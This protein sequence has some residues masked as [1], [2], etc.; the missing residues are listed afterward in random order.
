MSSIKISELPAASTATGAER[1]PVVQAGQTVS[2]TTA[3]I[4]ALA[5]TGG[6]GGGGGGTVTGSQGFLRVQDAPYNAAGTGGN[7][8]T[9]M[10]NAINSAQSAN[11]TL[12]IPP[13]TYFITPASGGG[14][15]IT[16]PLRIIADP[17]AT[18]IAAAAAANTYNGCDMINIRSNSVTIEGGVWDWN[19]NVTATLSTIINSTI[20]NISDVRIT[21]GTYQNAY[22]GCFNLQDVS[23]LD[24]GGC[25]FAANNFD[26]I[27]I[28]CVNYD[29]D[30]FLVHHTHPTCPSAN[31]EC[32]N[33]VHISTPTH[34]LSNHNVPHAFLAV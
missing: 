5:S 30:D 16:A 21:K 34:S 28:P 9:G 31:Y 6:G 1:V 20:G 17:R 25:H 32:V 14:L 8:T 29:F 23:H 7:Y 18:I 11:A 15:A 4:A 24:I 26:D 27:N 13:G 22:Y 12:V 19:N 10:Q 33:I 3:M 2:V